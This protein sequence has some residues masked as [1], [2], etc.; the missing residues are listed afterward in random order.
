MYNNI[1]Y[2]IIY[3]YTCIYNYCQTSLITG[4][5]KYYVYML[6]CTIVFMCEYS[7]EKSLEVDNRVLKGNHLYTLLT[8]IAFIL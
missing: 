1:I 4:T 3:L 6:L 5:I 2:I 8:I 7:T